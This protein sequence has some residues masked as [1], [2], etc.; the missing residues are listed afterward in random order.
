MAEQQVTLGAS[1]RTI[2][3]IGPQVIDIFEAAGFYTI[4]QLVN[5][6]GEDRKLLEVIEARKAAKNGAFP[7]SYWKRLA[8]RCIN[9]IYRA[10]SAEPLDFVPHEYMC[11]ITLDWFDDPVVTASGHSYSR[12]AI[13]NHLSSGR[14]QDPLT[15]TRIAGKP[16]YDN[17]ALKLAV[18]HYRRHHQ[19]Y[20][21]LS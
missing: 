13:L 6:D 17:V 20:S 7:T 5:F 21:I 14:D 18:E 10:R 2:E 3:G 9:I 8:T 11:P 16:L 1:I 15:G 12:E 4:E 19:L